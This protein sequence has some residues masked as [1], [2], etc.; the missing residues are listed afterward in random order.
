MAKLLVMPEQ[1]IIAGFKGTVDFYEWMGI[2]VARSWPRSPGKTRAPAVA[3]QWPAF[4]LAA[5]E[6]KNIS[7][8]VQAA[9]Y[10]MAQSSGLDA[11][12]LQVR[13]YLSGLYRYDT[14]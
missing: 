2:P 8:A 1:A 11:R 5:R 10:S 13:S 3:A 9:Y 12:D 6:W 4:A 14:P 7:A